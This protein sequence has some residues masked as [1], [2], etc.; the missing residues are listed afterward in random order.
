MKI[1]LDVYELGALR[2]EL[3]RLGQ[4]DSPPQAT[5][6]EFFETDG[7][8]AATKATLQERAEML[9][10]DLDEANKVIDNAAGQLLDMA[11]YAHSGPMTLPDLKSYITALASVL[12]VS[13][14]VPW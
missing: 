13:D 8:A 12:G 11:K 10:E 14:Q 1:E 7:T 9:R 3:N 2:D 5:E 6:R 4:T